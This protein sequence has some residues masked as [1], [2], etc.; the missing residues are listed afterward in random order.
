MSKRS[1]SA[2]VGPLGCLLLW[3]T[4]GVAAELPTIVVTPTRMAQS[5]EN[6]LSP[7]SVITREDIERT[8]APTLVE[9]LRLQAGVDVARTGGPGSQTS[10][11]LR[12]TNSN[13]VLVLVDGVRVSSASNGLF[14]FD[15]LLPSQAQ[16]IEIVRGPRAGL[17]GSD[18]IGGV[19]QVFTR[20]NAGANARLGGGSY[21]TS[22]ADAG[23]GGAVGERGR[24]SLQAAYENSRGFSASN[25]DAG[26]FVF[27]P[28]E[29]GYRNASLTASAG[30]ELGEIADIELRGW[31]AN[32]HNEFDQGTTDTLNQTLSA[33]L[34]ASLMADWEQ[35]L[36]V[37]QSR[38]DS[39]NE[40]DFSS[41]FETQRRSVNWQHDLALF[42]AGNLSAG[43]DYWR[44]DVVNDDLTANAN[45][46]DERLS[47]RGMYL[48]LQQLLGRWNLQA[49]LR[50]D[51]HSEFGGKSTGQVAAGY[52]LNPQLEL[53]GSYGTAFR[54][55]NA[56]ELFSPGFSFS[57]V[58][59][60]QFAGNPD[61]QP[62]TSASIEAGLR[63][64]PNSNHSV[65]VDL[66]HTDVDELIAFQGENFQAINVDEARLRGIELSYA[67]LW[68]PWLGRA[69][70][71]LQEAKEADTNQD[72]LRRPK[73]KLALQLDYNFSGGASFGGE[74]LAVSQRED[75]GST[76]PGY[77]LVNLR[78][79]VPLARDFTLEGRVE[80]LFDKFYEL[81]QG[82]NTPGLSVYVAVRWAPNS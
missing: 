52:A 16:R 4:Q 72:L 63:Y 49:A 35:S 23:W 66:Y 79:R 60:P 46:Y 58:L 10:V 15:R 6:S 54:A 41:R 43:V 61:L 75:V 59:P 20:D 34:R 69:A 7:M 40:S 3:S 5:G 12:G 19:V 48:G 57:P 29:D 2:L 51:S 11:F 32:G 24:A 47:N 74:F 71:T 76:L 68:G 37:A 42:G 25:P 21:G 31:H 14:A 80:N 82:F 36:L 56:N 77:G 28:D 26:P 73:R 45:V 17:Y 55:P 8:Q 38:D 70:V 65:A 9:A 22:S 18:A 53:I 33:R 81:A 44:D 30:V 27:D 50:H 64:Q 39:Q 78:G 1:L 67:G 62:E 13:H